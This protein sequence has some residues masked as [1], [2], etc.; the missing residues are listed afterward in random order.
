MR[1]F[2]LG[3]RRSASYNTCRVLSLSPTKRNSIYWR[4]EVRASR[5]LLIISYLLTLIKLV[6]LNVCVLMERNSLKET[7]LAVKRICELCL[8]RTDIGR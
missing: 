6:H 5:Y 4:R 2:L 3:W 7:R 1:R 8:G